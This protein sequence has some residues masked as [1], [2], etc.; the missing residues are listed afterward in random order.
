MTKVNDDGTTESDS[1]I[2]DVCED[3]RRA[4]D[5]A[6]LHCSTG[7][8]QFFSVL[9]SPPPVLSVFLYS[10]TIYFSFSSR[11]PPRHTFRLQIKT[12]PGVSLVHDHNEHKT[13]TPP[14]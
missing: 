6:P 7:L 1:G 10:T 8:S 5:C 4:A 13:P 12:V 9:R 2:P 14:R 3:G 11:T